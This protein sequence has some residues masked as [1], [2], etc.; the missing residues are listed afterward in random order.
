[1]MNNMIWRGVAASVTAGACWGLVFLAPKL[2]PGFLPIELS[3]GR[4]LA[5]GLIAALLIAPGWRRVVR[6]L[7]WR[8]WRALIWLSFMGNIFYYLCV[9]KAVQTGGI[10]MTSL[11]VGL[12]PLTVTLVGSR[13]RDALP[14]RRLLPSLVL[15][16]A[17]LLC[18]SWHA[19][20]QPGPGSWVGLLCALGALVAWTMYA[21]ANS[22]WLGRLESVSAHD[23]SLLT[24]VVTGVEALLLAVPAFMVGAGT[25]AAD[26]WWRFI[27]VVS[28]VALLCSVL[29]NGL[30][31]YASRMLPLTMIGQMIVFET[32]FALLYGFLYE[33]RLPGPLEWLAMALLAGG[34]WSCTAAH[35]PRAATVRDLDEDALSSHTAH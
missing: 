3:A 24:G 19:L 12:L 18:I 5:Y 4:Y 9:A 2:T 13:D 33:A 31:N 14:L 29:G 7:G 8:E 10:A 27:G 26:E 25:H 11:V 21:V 34:V 17:G 15:G 30:W 23:W 6:T 1:M 16:L 22:R 32:L 20:T 35:R 28:A